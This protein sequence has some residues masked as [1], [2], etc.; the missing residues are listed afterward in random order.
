MSKMSILMQNHP[1]NTKMTSVFTQTLSPAKLP[2]FWKKGFSEHEIFVEA[3]H[4]EHFS[5]VKTVHFETS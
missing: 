2:F 3:A 5:E 4:S 1:L